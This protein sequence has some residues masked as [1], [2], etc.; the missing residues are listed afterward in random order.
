MSAGS[1]VTTQYFHHRENID[2]ESGTENQRADG[3]L[4]LV[5]ARTDIR[6]AEPK[7]LTRETLSKNQANY[8]ID[9]PPQVGCTSMQKQTAFAG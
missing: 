4:E 1:I 9:P 5:A 6:P 2:W 8:R 3:R 7:D